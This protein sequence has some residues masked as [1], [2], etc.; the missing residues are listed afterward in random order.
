MMLHKKMIAELSVASETAD[1]FTF[2]RGGKPDVSGNIN[3]KGEFYSL[4]VSD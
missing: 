2:K 4:E 3:E 1:R